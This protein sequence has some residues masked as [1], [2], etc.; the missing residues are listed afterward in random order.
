M[1]S[2]QE[3]KG[4]QGF[5]S[6][7]EDKQKAIASKGGKTSHKGENTAETKSSNRSANAESQTDSE[8]DTGMDEAEE[9]NSLLEAFESEDLTEIDLDE[10][11]EMI[12]E[13][14]DTLTK[15]KDSD[16]KAVGSNLKQ[17]KKQLSSG[18]A[19]PE[20]LAELFTQLGE[21]VDSYANNA[22]RGY[23]TKLHNLGRS[24]KHA[25]KSLQQAGVE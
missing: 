8:T 5:A 16:L 12:E 1:A 15:S 11:T 19:Q 10:A 20:E 24:F 18:K 22:E 14:Q 23:K 7:D 13:W 9:L 2:K 21:Q 3:S 25:A 17:L 6:M 4:K